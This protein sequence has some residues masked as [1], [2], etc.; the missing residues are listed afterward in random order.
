VYREAR[1][2]YVGGPDED[3]YG[4]RVKRDRLKRIRAATRFNASGYVEIQNPWTLGWSYA[5]IGLCRQYLKRDIKA[6]EEEVHHVN[7]I[8]TDNS[9]KNLKLLSVGVHKA[10][11]AQRRLEKGKFSRSRTDF[12]KMEVMQ[13]PDATAEATGLHSHLK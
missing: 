2:F 5:H 10:L 7:C 9:E 11:H 1:Y 12:W 4:N 6:G 8:R 13:A 3:Q